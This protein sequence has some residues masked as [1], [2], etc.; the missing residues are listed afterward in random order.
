MMDTQAAL[1]VQFLGAH[2]ET[3]NV[4]TQL[5]LL[6]QIGANMSL[7]QRQRL[8]SKIT[9][10][11]HHSLTDHHRD[12]EQVL[13]PA[14]HRRAAGTDDAKLVVSLTTQLTR[15]H[16][17][18]EAIWSRIQPV[19]R[20]LESGEDVLIPIKASLGLAEQYA[21]HTAFEETVLLPMAARILTDGDKDTLDL[22]L[23]LRHNLQN[24]AI[25]I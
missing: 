12:E 15:E 21:A 16:R 4:L 22:S 7:E 24:L 17:A 13:F 19:L 14:L 5:K 8:A 1:T 20:K 25:H 6:A 11:L 18:S 9:A 2:A 10:G 3:L 23:A